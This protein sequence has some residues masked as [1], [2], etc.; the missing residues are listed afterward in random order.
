MSKNKNI[1]NEN[2]KPLRKRLKKFFK[3]DNIV[4]IVLVV[5]TL[6]LVL[7]S[8]LPYLFL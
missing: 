8:F 4:K 6:A 5:A 1:E 2:R 3:K 7:G